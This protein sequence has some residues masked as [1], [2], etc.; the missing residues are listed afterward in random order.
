[1]RAEKMPDSLSLEDDGEGQA[2]HPCIVIPGSPFFL[3][4]NVLFMLVL[5]Y[6]VIVFPLNVFNIAGH[7]V[8]YA[9]SVASVVFW[10]MDL[11]LSF[12]VAYYDKNG[13]VV[14]EHYKIMVHY[15]R[16]WMFPDLIV[17][18]MDWL[19]VAGVEQQFLEV[20]S[21]FRL[22]KAVRY[23]RFLRLLRVLRLRKLREAILHVD[24]FINS[25]YFTIIRSIILNMLGILLSSHFIGCFWYFLGTRKNFG[26]AWVDY[27]GYKNM[28]WEYSYLTA[29]HW[30]LT[31]FTPGS[32]EIQPQNTIERLYAVIILVFGM[33]VFSS[34]VSNITAATNSLKNMNARY[35]KQ[36]WIL[37][38]YFKEQK[39][40]PCLL[41]K[42]VRYAECVVKTK[43][44][45]VAQHE[46]EMLQMLPQSLYMD[47][48]L[49]L[50][51]QYLSVH[52]L[53]KALLKRNKHIMQLV[54]CFAVSEIIL[55]TGDELFTPGQIA[56]AM[57]FVVE[58][59]L[60]YS[61]NRIERQENLQKGDNVCE[62]V[63]WTPWVHQGTTIAN[64]ESELLSLDSGKFREVVGKFHA[65]VWI[66]Q[67]YGVEFVLRMN[68]QAGFFTDDPSDDVILSDTLQIAS[69]KE[70]LTNSIDRS[71][72]CLMR[73]SAEIA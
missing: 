5:C 23:L 71:K 22:G 48:R 45:R 63:L 59:Y 30:S 15:A 28:T 60:T 67:K 1:M 21:V 32:M 58:G 14:A 56:H 68:E 17:I 39:I 35:N 62:A 6:E 52:P 29:L 34:I 54:C 3:S 55:S 36:L 69:A 37:R 25:Q 20:A 7:S 16:T 73:S 40:S 43:T 12:F 57:Y 61:L 42:V 26:T 2:Y 44:R 31:Q 27:Y 33:I 49:E 66:L 72:S 18:F 47:V 9:L 53:F 38:R 65:D 10:T 13:T 41:S 50:Y 11:V 24:E 51:D 64:V 70:I 19:A 4:W 8:A 46:V